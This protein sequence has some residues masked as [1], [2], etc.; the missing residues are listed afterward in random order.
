MA[1][2]GLCLL[3]ACASHEVRSEVP[4]HEAL[5]APRGDVVF[6]PSEQLTP[7]ELACRAEELPR[8]N[9][10]DDD[11]DGRVD[12]LEATSGVRIHLARS[13][14]S[15]QLVLRKA[16]SEEGADV[17]RATS[18]PLARDEAAPLD[19]ADA[20]GMEGYTLQRLDLPSPAN[21]SYELV[22]QL[23]QPDAAP[24]ALAVTVESAQGVRTYLAHLEA[25]RAVVLGRLDVR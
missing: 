12:G 13:G 17:A 11:C 19:H 23:T 22:V 3:G 14:A 21:G 18:V 9:G 15:A 25:E 5:P 24:G 10:L 6:A 2:S 8:E 7:L 4:R 1:T 20:L 16:G